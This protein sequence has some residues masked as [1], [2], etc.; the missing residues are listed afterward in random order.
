MLRA[1]DERG[2]G[3]GAIC[4]DALLD[5]EVGMEVMR[6]DEAKGLGDEGTELRSG[7][8]AAEMARRKYSSPH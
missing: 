8:I 6:G 2:S 3:G 5:L 7:A 1:G 4:C